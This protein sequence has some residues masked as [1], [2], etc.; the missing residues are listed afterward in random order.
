MCH[1]VLLMPVIGL[2]VFWLW[3]FS[4]A[5]PVYLIILLISGF[6]YFAMLKAMHRP[7]TT[8]KEGLIGKS[9]DIVDMAGSKGHVRVH[10]EIWEAVFE[11]SF[12]KTDKGAVK[13]V[14]DMTL[15]IE[16][17]SSSHKRMNGARHHH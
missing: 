17:E 13:S 10:G 2:G 16:K 12:Q 3:P 7:V 1:L 6:V 9:V 14:Q 11:D 8:G 4:V 5:M 15:V